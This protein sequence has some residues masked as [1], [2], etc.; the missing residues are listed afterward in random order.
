MPGSAIS[1]C[2]GHGEDNRGR[3]KP[4]I[5]LAIIGRR[6]LRS[7]RIPSRVLIRQK[8]V[9]AGVLGGT[10][11][12]DNIGDIGRKFHEEEATSLP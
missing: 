10:G 8:S 9:G 12:G 5:P 3:K 6:V 2:D 11:D 1:S 7:M 4:P